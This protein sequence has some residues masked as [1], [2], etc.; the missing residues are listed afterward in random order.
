[1]STTLQYVVSTPSSARR[2]VASYFV[3][4][5]GLGASMAIVGP[6]LPGLA[7]QTGVTLA[8]LSVILVARSLGYM[9]GALLGGWLYDHSSG[10]AV[11]AGGLVVGA[12]A[13]AV[14]PDLPS[15]WL[16]A[17]VFL[18][19]GVA[20]SVLDVGGN[21][22][23]IWFYG[24][25]SGPAMNGL[26]FAFGVG[27][28]A[29]PLVVVQ[30]VQ[31]TGTYD[32]AYRALAAL[33]VLPVV[34]LLRLPSPR[35]AQSEEGSGVAVRNSTLLVVLFALLFLFYVGT[36]ASFGDWIYTYGIESRLENDVTS[37]YLT[38]AFWAVFT[39]GRLLAIPVAARVRPSLILLVDLLGAVVVL[40]ALT[41]WGNNQVVL[42]GGTILLGLALA[43]VFA[44]T[45]S[46][47]E[48]L[49]A[50]SGRVTSIFFVG[51]SGGAML[52][53]WLTGQALGRFG[54]SSMMVVF[55]ISAVLCLLALV[56]IMAVGKRRGK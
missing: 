49:L 8:A 56:A 37:G 23:L 53:S 41:L 18:V 9:V 20:L 30:I 13:I 51:A 21:T 36:E 43:S 44:A 54:P 17:A 28:L 6:T 31:W 50:I 29:A 33:I 26:H 32:W 11:M 39:I 24:S 52:F 48:R 10:H 38:S 27:A 4:Y 15:L 19:M 47:A 35:N 25:K 55:L 5:A 40:T 34:F 46:L 42:W 1:M 7:A 14:T 2:S 16:L 45:F 3:A 22:L 12:V